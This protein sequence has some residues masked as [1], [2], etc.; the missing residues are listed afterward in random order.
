[1]NLQDLPKTQPLGDTLGARVKNWLGAR[2]VWNKSLAIYAAIFYAVANISYDA[3]RLNDFRP[4]W[5]PI[6]AG[7]YVEV[8]AIIAFLVLLLPKRWWRSAAI[9]IWLNL[10]IAAVAG[11]V[12]NTTVYWW[13]VEAGLETSAYD[14]LVR[15]AGGAILGTG[16]LASWAAMSASRFGHQNL[17]I[18]LRAKQRALLSYRDTVG[19]QVSNAQQE[20]VNQTKQ[21]LLPKLELL[22]SRLVSDSD[23]HSLVGDLQ[24][25]I[26]RDVRPLSRAFESEAQQLSA[27]PK[28]AELK[29]E[30]KREFPAQFKLRENLPPLGA[31]AMLLPLNA[32]TAY[33]L[34]GPGQVPLVVATG[35][36]TLLVLVLWRLVSPRNKLTR[37]AIGLTSLL[38]GSAL[39][40]L[41]QVL[42]VEMFVVA[43]PS[44]KALL[45]ASLHGQTALGIWM[46]AYI[47]I[48]DD[49]RVDLEAQ[50]V[51]VN[52]SLNHE[53]A[54]F[55]QA[56]WLQKRRWSYLLHGTVQATLTAAMARLTSLTR[57]TLEGGTKQTEAG[58]ILELVRQ[59]LRKITAAITNP[60]KLQ[61]DLMYELGQLQQT[62]QGVLDISFTVSER[63]TRAIDK[64]LNT[65]MALNEICREAATNAF[66]HGGATNLKIKI[67]RNVDNEIELSIINNGTKPTSASTG[68]GLQMFDALT[69][70]W[71]WDQSKTATQTR[72]SARLP[73]AVN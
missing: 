41:P 69:I 25:I 12:K 52:E 43:D 55:S 22:E 7:T 51:K 10:G 39:V 3:F 1:M 17:M 40:G 14:P 42:L 2:R 73:L 24:Q 28:P 27:A 36:V 54:V 13:A 35:A 16:I 26:E 32:L 64:S 37:R 21:T 66:R 30:A 34:V 56:L 48:V 46:I 19:L 68:L 29:A 31:L 47:N 57:T 38:V 50:M 5:L 8:V 67:D 4:E 11:A 59:D 44:T 45:A 49:A 61:L 15:I 65:R 70:D 58:M 23:V 63:A 72:L 71:G 53:L 33:M 20:L 18:E 62:W 60:P 9:G 6:W